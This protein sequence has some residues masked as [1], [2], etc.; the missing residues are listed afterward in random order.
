[1]VIKGRK[2][3]NASKT[4]KNPAKSFTKTPGKTPRTGGK[5][6]S[7]TS[8]MK[9]R[10]GQGQGGWVGENQVVHLTKREREERAIELEATALRRAHEVAR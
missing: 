9:Q 3:S 4:S 7:R 2:N 5:L 10:Q 6:R 8:K 1:M